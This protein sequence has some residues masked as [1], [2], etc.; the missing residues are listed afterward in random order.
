MTTSVSMSKWKC[1]GCDIPMHDDA[2]FCT[3]C[4]DAVNIAIDGGLSLGDAVKVVRQIV[5]SAR[6]LGLA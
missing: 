2:A 5:T 4:G 3:S 1:P 6:T